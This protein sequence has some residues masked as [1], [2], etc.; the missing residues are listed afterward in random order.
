M[1]KDLLV[2]KLPQELEQLSKGVSVEKRNEVQTVLNHVFNGVTKMREQLD[3][4]NVEDEDDKA[5]MK[6]ANAIRLNVREVRLNAEKTFDAKRSEVQ[7]QM[8][9]FKTED[10]LWLKAKQTMQ[11]LTKE[12][13]EIAKWKEKTKERA[14]AQRKE[15]KVQERISDVAKFNPELTRSEFE[16]MSDESFDFFLKGIEKQ[17]NERIEAEKKAEADRLAAI[18]ADRLERER[19]KA[20]N[21][22]LQREAE[23]KE[24]QLQAERMKAQ[25]EAQREAEK[26]ASI[27]AAEKAE[28]KRIQDLKDAEN[29]RLQKELRA[30]QDAEKAIEDARIASEAKAKQDAAKAAKAPIKNKLTIWVDSFA[31]PE[32]EENATAQ[33]IKAK[34]DGFKKWA[35]SEIQKL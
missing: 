18:E 35:Q 21:E 30:K 2:V 24:K 25:R 19:I 29:E 12:I 13:E 20:E 3:A 1:E 31:I 9:S 17:Y 5:S 8:L 15:E 34:F 22:R 16:S 28:A 33:E 23:E 6:V 32:F 7:S 14:D 11:I 27:L 4:V 10:A 26:Q